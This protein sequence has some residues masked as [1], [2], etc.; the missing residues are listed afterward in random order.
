MANGFKLSDVLRIASIHPFYSDAEYPPSREDLLNLLAKQWGPD[1]DLKLSS[2][3]LTWKGALYK[4]IARLTTD[5]DPRNGYR[6]Q[7]YISTTGGGSGKGSPMVFATDSQETRQQRAAIGALL[8]SCGVTGPGDWVMTMHVSGHLYRAL[9]LMAETFEGSGASVLCA[10][11]LMEPDQMIEI[12]LEYRVNAIAGD[13]SQIMQLSRYICTLPDDT[14]KQ[15]LINKVIY[16]SEPMTPVQRKF[17]S[18]VFPNVAVSSVIGS[19]EAGPWATSPAQLTEAS[20]GQNYADFVYDQRLMHLE[21]FPFDIEESDGAG[22]ASARPVPDGEKGLLVQT[23]LQRMRHPLIRYVCGDVCSLHPL[24]ASMKNIIPVEDAAHYKVAR[25]YGRDRRISFDWYGEYFEFAVI[26]DAMRTESWGILQYQIIRR[27]NGGDKNNLDIVLELRVLRHNEP[28]TISTDELTRELPVHGIVSVVSGPIIGHFADQCSNRKLP[29]L[30]SLFAC[31]FGTGMVAGATSLPVLFTGRV[32]QGIAGSSVWIIGLATVADTVGGD[33][34]GK[35]EGIMMSFLYGGLI[36]RPCIAGWLLAYVGYWP[37]WL[38]PLV[39]LLLDFIARLV[40]VENCAV[41]TSSSGPE[42]SSKADGSTKP[43]LSPCEDT[44][45]NYPSE[46]FWRII[47]TDVRAVVA[48]CVA[49]SANTVG[50][51]FHAT[52]PLHVQETFGWGSGRSGSLFACLIM[53]TVVL[54]PVAG[55]LRDCFGVR[56]PASAAAVFQAV[57]FGIL[58]LAGTD[59]LPWT[60][61]Q[62]GGGALYTGC[63]LAIGAARPFTANVGP[64][65]LSS[66]VR[67]YQEKS[68]GIF[69][70]EGGMSRVFSLDD[71]AASLGTVL[72]PIIGGFLTQYKGY[73]FM[74]FTWSVIYIVLATLVLCVLGRDHASKSDMCDEVA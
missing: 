64:V 18:S 59:L 47:L 49:I 73:D 34:M 24:P 71:V 19:A 58:G 33:N 72:G 48:I 20:K 46:N 43:L 38:L 65:E 61:A 31:I 14:R 22:L 54:S 9:D 15:L 44:P 40:M 68:P 30:F 12:L 8:R 27:Y 70:P 37:T 52:L 53:P 50:T 3:P 6:Q 55:W 36:G 62:S 32:M 67:E 41:P 2:F 56:Y 26:Q 7:V 11:S 42:T 17:L 1:R 25:L 66:I 60:S 13:T 21:V 57:M 45:T 10:G 23:S 39:L 29:L 51:S 28:G 35:V 69:G 63:I 16:T 4:K 5:R 74:C